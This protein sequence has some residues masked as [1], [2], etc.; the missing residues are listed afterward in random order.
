MIIIITAIIIMWPVV[1]IN[2]AKTGQMMHS[3]R[4]A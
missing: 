3:Y 4:N 2:E 1:Y